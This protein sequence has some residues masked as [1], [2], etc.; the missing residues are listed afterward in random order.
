[1]VKLVISDDVGAT[2]VVPLVRDEISIGRGEGNTIRLTERNISRKHAVL[3]K[4]D[5]TYVL[6]DL[7]SYNG[8]SING[9][10]IVDEAEVRS[11]DRIRIGDYFLTLDVEGEAQA[12]NGERAYARDTIPITEASSAVTATPARLVLLTQPVPGIEFS[13]RK[14]STI[15][16][17]RDE[18][19]DIPIVHSSV[20]REHAEVRVDDEGVYISDLKS[21]NGLRINGNNVEHGRLKSGDIIEIGEVVLRYVAAGE[22]YQFDPQE[23]ARFLKQTRKISKR[24]LQIGGAAAIAVIVLILIVVWSRQGDSTTVSPLIDERENIPSNTGKLEAINNAR[25]KE[26]AKALRDCRIAIEGSRFAEAIAYATKALEKQPDDENASQCKSAAERQL[27]QEQIFVRGKASL[28]QGDAEGAYVEFLKLDKKSAFKQRPEVGRATEE[29]ARSQIDLAWALVKNDKNKASELAASVLEMADAPAEFHVAAREI[30]ESLKEQD[31]V[32]VAARTKP[33][34]DPK[35]RAS[36]EKNLQRVANVTAKE[37]AAAKRQSSASRA[38]T[39]AG[40]QSDQTRFREASACLARGDNKCIIRLLAGKAKT[41]EE[42][43][44][45][46]ETY[47]S[48]GDSKSALSSMALYVKRYPS[49]R[50]TASYQRI[51]ERNDK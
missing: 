41:P 23:A 10:P 15:R 35:R 26:F 36:V 17:G 40:E 32:A 25:D 1:M 50:R 29:F 38:E 37:K 24:Q 30:Q 13:L 14:N 6:L 42:L 16:I 44:L 4:K 45:L 43:G 19:L 33:S 22:S 11:G 27:E 18:D 21:V 39:S 48:I 49:S 9:K 12:E 47:R 31:R 5:E 3:K 51:L 34:A 8:V 20:S 28:E 46:I 7:G 2:T